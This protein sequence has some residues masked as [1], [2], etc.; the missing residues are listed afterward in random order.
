[1]NTNFKSIESTIKYFDES[2]VEY[3]GTDKKV[4]H[5]VNKDTEYD[6]LTYIVK[7]LKDEQLNKDYIKYLLSFSNVYDK[8]KNDEDELNKFYKIE[9]EFMDSLIEI[10]EYDELLNKIMNEVKKLDNYFN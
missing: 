6:N 10:N 8:I 4:I 1:M 2:G 5:I 9:N 3:E 7:K